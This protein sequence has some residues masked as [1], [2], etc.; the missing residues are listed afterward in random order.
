[1]SKEKLI[2]RCKELQIEVPEAATAKE[3][4]NLI[5]IT[6]HDQLTVDLTTAK[7]GLEVVKN[8]LVAQKELTTKAVKDRD[9]ESEKLKTATAT[10]NSLTAELAATKAVSETKKGATYKSDNETFT[11]AVEKFRFQGAEHTAAAAVKND[12]LMQDLIKSKFIHLKK[13]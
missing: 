11:F 6:E 12:Q 13:Q 9:A 8:E 5:K 10:I 2:A 4:A 1:M 7:E 3:M